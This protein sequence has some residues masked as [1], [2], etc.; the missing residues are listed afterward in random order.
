MA[1]STS[2]TNWEKIQQGVK[3][4]E[5]RIGQKDY[6]GAMVKARQ[7][8]EFMVKLQA[9]RAGIAETAELKNLI[10][11]LYQ[12][13]W[14]SKAT[15]EHY[16]KI[17]IIGNK[18]VHEGDTNAYNANQSYHA[19]S[20]EVYT[21]AND[22]RNAKRGTRQSSQA[23][24]SSST[25]K[26]TATGSTRS[27]KRKQ[28]KGFSFTVY[29]LLKILIPILCIILLFLVVRLV[30]PDSDSKETTA[31]VT[32]EAQLEENT[33][34]ET[35]PEET[36]AEAAV[37]YRTTSVLNVRSEP[38]TEGSRIGQLE[39]GAVVDYVG[40]YDGDWTIIRYNDM[41]AYVASAYL[42]TE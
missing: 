40:V 42:T 14:I 4:V 32:T 27:R 11:T 30:K 31:E 10:D 22:Y 15:C 12:N 13:H 5:K 41:E 38:S 16:H 33:E 34:A 25:G 24:R 1:A 28:S 39:A 36:E 6:N 35:Q 7:T 3:D 37:V 19:L 21:F 18:A 17:R 2:N 20:Q 26:S 9:A 23:K 29:D 8:L